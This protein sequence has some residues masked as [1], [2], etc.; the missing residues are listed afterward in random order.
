VRSEDG[1]P[2]GWQVIRAFDQWG[3][4]HGARF[5]SKFACRFTTFT[6][7]FACVKEALWHVHPLRTGG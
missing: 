1:L 3:C 6:V 2:T 7:L 5:G 4:T